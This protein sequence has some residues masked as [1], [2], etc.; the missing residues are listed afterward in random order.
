MPRKRVSTEE[1]LLSDGPVGMS[2]G[3][4]AFSSLLVN[5]EGF[6]P[7]WVVSSLGR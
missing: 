3:H 5:V 6:G 1:L 2:V 7:L 4:G